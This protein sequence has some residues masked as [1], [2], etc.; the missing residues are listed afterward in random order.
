MRCRLSEIEATGPSDL[1]FATRQTDTGI[2]VIPHPQTQV[3]STPWS[4]R[5]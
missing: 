4:I 5:R 3:S 2:L 1:C